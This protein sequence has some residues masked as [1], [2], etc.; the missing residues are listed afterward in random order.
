[1][2]CMFLYFICTFLLF[3]Q[4]VASKPLQCHTT[5]PATSVKIWF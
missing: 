1:M 5:V 2:N 4:I 3:D